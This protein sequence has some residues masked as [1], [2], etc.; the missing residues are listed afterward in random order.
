MKHTHKSST[1]ITLVAM[2]AA[3]IT[4]GGTLQA[5]EPT[6]QP[7]PTNAE[8]AAHD[9]R[10]AWWR[11]ARFGMFIHWGLYAVPAG[12]WQGKPVP[13]YGE[14]IMSRAKIP[15][16]DYAKFAGQFNPTQFDAEAWAQLAQDAGMKYLTITAKHHDGFAM[17]GSKVSNYNI[18]DA[19]P[20]KHGTS[21]GA[22][23]LARTAQPSAT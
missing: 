17:F 3:F 6:P 15:A 1:I 19:T 10:I 7:S 11:E 21:E 18:V 23:C 9:A 16:A 12:E 20:W 5:R 22:T 14:W 13:A 8:Q 2:A 4:S